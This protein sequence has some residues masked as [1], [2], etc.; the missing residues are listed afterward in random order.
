MPLRSPIVRLRRPAGKTPQALKCSFCGKREDEV[1]QL[2]AGPRVWICS[3]CVELCVEIL[4][5]MR[6]GRET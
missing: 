1:E 6:R 4:D 5:E 2:I 3:E